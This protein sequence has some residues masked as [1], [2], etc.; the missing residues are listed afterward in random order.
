M[1]LTIRHIIMTLA[2]LALTACHNDPPVV[3]Q[4]QQPDNYKDNMINANR[5]IAQSEETSIN[6]YV[7]RRGWPVKTLSNGV[8]VWEYEAGDGAKVDYEDS[9]HAYYSVEA[10][11]GTLIYPA[12]EEHFVAGRKPNM[13]GLDDAVLSLHH[14][15]R[16]KVIL[17][18]ALAYGIAGDGDRITQS[19]ILVIDLKIK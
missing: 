8:R 1:N 16:A 14:G 3:G 6:E 11:N 9:I 5:T 15:S 17:P 7:A 18:S 13:T 4:P 12:E 2:A 19:A 10:I